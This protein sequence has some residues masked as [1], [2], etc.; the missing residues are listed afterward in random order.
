MLTSHAKHFLEPRVGH[1]WFIPYI[2][3]YGCVVCVSPLRLP[4]SGHENDKCHDYLMTL[5]QMQTFVAS[6]GRIIC[7]REL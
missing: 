7:E 3:M 6:S 1:P 5:L 2:D 4:T